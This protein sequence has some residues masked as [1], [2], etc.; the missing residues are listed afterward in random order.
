MILYTLVVISIVEAVLISIIFF[1]L[2]YGKASST[3]DR[4]LIGKVNTSIETL[5]G[6]TIMELIYQ[7]VTEGESPLLVGP[8]TVVLDDDGMIYT[9]NSHWKLIKIQNVTE[10]EDPKYLIADTEEI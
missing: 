3:V 6:N 1:Q 2:P 4:P 5:S 7:N 9:L 10:T 8:E